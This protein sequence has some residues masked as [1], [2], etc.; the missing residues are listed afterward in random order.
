MGA[1]RHWEH[2]TSCPKRHI[3]SPL[4]SGDLRWISV[5]SPPPQ[6]N[7]TSL[8]CLTKEQRLEVER[9]DGP[10]SCWMTSLF[11]LRYQLRQAAVTVCCEPSGFQTT[12]THFLSPQGRTCMIRVPAWS[13]SGEDPLLGCRPPASHCVLTWWKESGRELSG[14]PVKKALIPFVRT[15]PHDLMTSQSSSSSS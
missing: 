13:G 4:M 9:T 6:K 5:Y 12:E 7:L 15:P 10:R 2:P 1:A 14:V 11:L 8:C 3:F